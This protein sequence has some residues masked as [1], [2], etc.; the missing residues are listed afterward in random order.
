MTVAVAPPRRREPRW[1]EWLRRYAPAELLALVGALTGYL[2][3]EMTT[4]SRAVAALGAAMGDNVGYYAVIAAREIA[5]R[6]DEGQRHAVR[7][8]LGALM[9][10]F[11]PA[12]ALDSAL[13]RPACTAIATA[14]LGSAAG[15]VAAKLVA[16]LVFYAPVIASYEL[17]KRREG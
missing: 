4:G 9:L 16:D 15:V 17:R 10:E 12:E 5:A 8:G 14:A 11:G 3:L 1:E 7:R 13:V 2:L 6:R